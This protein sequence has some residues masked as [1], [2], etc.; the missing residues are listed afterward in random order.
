[1]HAGGTI[2]DFGDE[3]DMT[4]YE[5]YS[6]IRVDLK[7]IERLDIS[8]AKRV[9]MSF[10]RTEKAGLKD[11][12][13]L[14]VV[15]IGYGSGRR[16][17]IVLIAGL[18]IGRPTRGG[19]PQVVKRL[20]TTH[21]PAVNYYELFAER[22]DAAH[23]D[24]ELRKSESSD[25]E[26]GPS[27]EARREMAVFHFHELLKIVRK[28]HSVAVDSTRSSLVRSTHL[29][30]SNVHWKTRPPCSLISSEHGSLCFQ[31]NLARNEEQ[32]ARRQSRRP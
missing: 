4:P 24:L 7:S 10:C 19:T 13:Y 28:I 29:K 23:L 32:A 5:R 18:R 9:R 21:G 14:E 16:S 3:D 2:H 20:D 12:K 6:L 31:R 30:I 1:M 27:R 17:Q 25:V 15:H 8:H 22:R 11:G 26:R